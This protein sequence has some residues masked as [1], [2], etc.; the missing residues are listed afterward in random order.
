[1]PFDPAAY[2]RSV[3]AYNKWVRAVDE[4]L[5]ELCRHHP[6]HNDHA[7]VAAKCWIIGR[8][9]ATG[10]ERQIDSDG[11]QGGS[12][13]QL[14]AYL[15]AHRRRIDTLLEELRP[16]ES[17]LT[18]DALRTIVR[19]HGRF[20]GVLNGVVR[21]NETPR[22]FA[23]K[24]LHFH[25]PLVPIYDSVAAGAIPGQ[26]RWRDSLIVFPQPAGADEHY[27]RFCYRFWNLH[28]EARRAL[29]KKTTVKLLDYYLIY[30]GGGPA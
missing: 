28:E 7:G 2:H 5:Y 15:R 13:S 3:A 30:L 19:V 26:V 10:V 23:S 1:M 21:S 18:I 25:C 12:M 4:A 20:L 11:K 9:Y 27:A 24:Y 22:A 8:T 29:G 17:P 14:V 16:L 6:D